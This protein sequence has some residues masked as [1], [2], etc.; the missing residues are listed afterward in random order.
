MATG[1]G[2]RT[3]ARYGWCPIM[4]AGAI[5][6]VIGKAAAGVWPMIIVGIAAGIETIAAMSTTETGAKAVP[7]KYS[8]S[9]AASLIIRPLK[10]ILN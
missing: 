4:M 6:K 10:S 5:T 9:P 8:S 7:G 2:L 1:R 3:P